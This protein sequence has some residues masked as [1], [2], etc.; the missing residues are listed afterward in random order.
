MTVA[1]PPEQ[2]EPSGDRPWQHEVIGL[3]DR[4]LDHHGRFWRLLVLLAVLVALAL[5][6]LWVLSVVPIS[7]VVVRR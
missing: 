7:G 2:E 4:S 6:V 3:V 5:A 1:S